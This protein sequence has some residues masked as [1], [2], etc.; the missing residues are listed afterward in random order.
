VSQSPSAALPTVGVV[1]ATRGRPELLRAAVRAALGQTYAGRVEIRVVFDHIDIDPLG[2][3]EVPDNRALETLANVRPQGLAGARNSGILASDTELIAFCDDDDEW[4]PSKLEA[5]VELLLSRPEAS[6]VAT[7]IRIES[8]GGSHVRLPPAEANFGDFLVS[9]ITEIHPSSF[10]IRRDDLLG[11]IGLVDEELPAAYGEDYDLLLRASRVGPVLSVLEPLT[12]INWKRASFFSSKWDGI[13][14]GLTYVLDKFPEFSRTR[15]GTARIAGQVA[16][17]HAAS[18]R[19]REA[20]RWAA[21]AIRNDVAEL[22]AY[23]AVA[24]S[25]RLAPA[26]ALVNVI[27]RRGRGL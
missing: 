14:S 1:I 2:D 3:V 12:I 7:G 11:P 13:A 18:G 24:I 17:A 22:R 8:E 5:Q 15:R 21:R 23:A 16:F 4:L 10:L 6:V 26:G 19:R 27:N 9:R 25:L 20:N